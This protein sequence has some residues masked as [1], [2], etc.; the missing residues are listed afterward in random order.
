MKIRVLIIENKPL[1][2]SAYRR[3][4]E[5]KE[6]IQIV[7]IASNGMDGYD[8]LSRSEVDVILCQLNMPIMDGFEFTTKVM[9]EHPKPIL[10]LT[11]PFQKEKKDNFFRVLELGALD[12]FTEL[13]VG[14]DIVLFGEELARKIRVINRVV[15]FKKRTKNIL[16]E[17][18]NLNSN[19]V[20][21]TK[22][23]FKILAIGAST[24]GPQAYQ[25]LLNKIPNSFPIPIVC[26][27]HIS[28]G[29]S[30]GL[31]EWLNQ[32]S[33]C[34]V[35]FAENGL[36]PEPGVVYFPTDDR[37]LSL[38]SGRLLLTDDPQVNGHRP[39]VDYLF[40]SIASEHV[41]SALGVLLTGMGDDGAR[42][43]KTI[44]ETGGFTIAQDESSSTVYGMPRVAKELDPTVEVLALDEI[45]TRILDLVRRRY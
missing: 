36:I 24:G 39:S 43:L 29:F 31:L 44:K 14:G 18:L 38:K 25:A 33:P 34:T 15:V 30:Q 17:Y 22:E 4:L 8:I 21:N 3:A 5:K 27:Q 40:R 1:T 11:D 10:I 45:A 26:V 9:A 13:N 12:V 28:P 35:Q 37:H 42:G 20:T 6:D 2:Q 7:A 23:K 32:T 16:A 19:A 41:N